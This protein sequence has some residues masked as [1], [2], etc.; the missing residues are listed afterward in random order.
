LQQYCKFRYTVAFF[1]TFSIVSQQLTSSQFSGNPMNIKR[2]PAG[3]PLVTGLASH[4]NSITNIIILFHQH[5][6]KHLLAFILV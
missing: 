6:V 1:F 4:C 2:A 5:F 3:T